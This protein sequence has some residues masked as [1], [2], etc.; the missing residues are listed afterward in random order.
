MK[1]VIV[2]TNVIAVVN[3]M[4][5]HADQ[6]CILA[7]IS[8]LQTA[9]L[10]RKIL[11]D[12]SLFIF[13]EYFRY[14]S[15]SGQPHLGDAFVKWLWDNQANIRHCERVNITPCDD[16]YENFEE[17]PS[18]AELAGFHGDDRK[19]VA[20]ALASRKKPKIL[21]AVDTDWWIFRTQLKNHNI[22]IQFLCPQLMD[23]E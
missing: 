16:N 2:E 19:F 12:A 1:A 5:I 4:A 15:R 7:C 13:T 18:D 17:F 20:V 23:N 3:Q 22:S 9:R 14:A 6:A 8:A 21:N 10:K 11:I